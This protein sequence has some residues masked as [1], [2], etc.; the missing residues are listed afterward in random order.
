MQIKV[1][2]AIVICQYY[3]SEAFATV[4]WTTVYFAEQFVHL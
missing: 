4:D 2:I 1:S 3:V